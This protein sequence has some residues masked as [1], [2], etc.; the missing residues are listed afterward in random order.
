VFISLL[1][2]V[3]APVAWRESDCGLPKRLNVNSL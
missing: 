2:G 1:P 3:H